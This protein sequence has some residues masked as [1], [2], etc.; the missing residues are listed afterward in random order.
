MRDAGYV[1]DTKFVLHDVEDERKDR[2][3]LYH[4]EKLAI[5]YGL[6]V[7]M[8]GTSLHVMKNLRICRDCHTAMKI[9]TK[10]V[11][12]EIIV[13]DGYRFHHFRKGVCSC[14]DYW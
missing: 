4:S 11:G 10:V 14:G 12:R 7:T 13:R 3:L 2:L 8:P 5:T 6:M 9:S 1:P